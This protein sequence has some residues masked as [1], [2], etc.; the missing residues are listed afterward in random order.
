V[1]LAVAAMTAPTRRD[2]D[3]PGAPH[4][5]LSRRTPH[6]SAVWHLPHAL[7]HR[8]MHTECHMHSKVRSLEA[9]REQMCHPPSRTRMIC[10]DV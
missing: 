2:E 8:P 7:P 9:Q 1:S 10:M 6:I 3:A 5:Q 4:P